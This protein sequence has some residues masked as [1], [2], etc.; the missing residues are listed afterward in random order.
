[1]KPCN[2]VIYVFIL[3]NYYLCPS[4][5]LFLATKSWQRI[6]ERKGKGGETEGKRSDEKGGK[7]GKE[8]ERLTL[9]TIGKKAICWMQNIGKKKFCDDMRKYNLCCGLVKVT[10]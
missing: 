7:G 2:D 3:F 10:H 5:H 4:S 6:S 1:M 8:R 9:L